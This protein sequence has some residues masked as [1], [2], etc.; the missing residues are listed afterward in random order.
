M[1]LKHIRIDKLYGQYQINT[2]I[3]S[4]LNI[5]VGNNGSYKTTMLKTIYEGISMDGCDPS[6]NF[7]TFALDF[8]NEGVLEYYKNYRLMKSDGSLGETISDV[9]SD[10]V[11]EIINS[12]ASVDNEKV[13]IPS[14]I[15]KLNVSSVF[16][17][18]IKGDNNY[19][20]SSYLTFILESLLTE[21]GAYL[22]D[23]SE[24]I[25]IGLKAGDANSFTEAFRTREIFKDIINNAFSETAKSL[26]NVSKMIFTKKSNDKDVE[27]SWK[28]LSSGEKQLIIILLTA[29]LQRG[30]ESI[31]IMDEPEI[32]MHITWQSQLLD[33]IYQLNPNVQVIM[34]THSPSIFGRGWASKIIYM[35]DIL[36]ETK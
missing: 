12:R 29:L 18:D 35:D 11:V 31:L 3:D 20:D 1:K 32:S 25:A 30:E 2:D 13:D 5:F 16:T 7:N 28:A 15:S 24:S 8:T 10:N 33:W 27:I 6:Y 23:L 34:S 22:A 9:H 21:Y 17:Y 26:S 19:K 4:K 36:A 14:F